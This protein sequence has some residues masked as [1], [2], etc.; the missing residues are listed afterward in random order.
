MLWLTMLVTVLHILVCLVLI[1]VVLLQQGGKA[2]LGVFAGAGSQTAFGGAGPATILHKLTIGAAVIFM[3]TC[4]FLS[5]NPGKSVGETDIT[6]GLPKTQAAKPVAPAP[7]TPA[8]GTSP[9]APQGAAPSTPSS[10][11][12]EGGSGA[13]KE[14][15]ATTGSTQPA[16]AP[17][18]QQPA[19]SATGDATKKP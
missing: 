11:T 16:G 6:K 8:P 19:G 14:T 5:L 1:L 9:G 18:A 4:L 17:A 7:G 12:T 15:G 3:I 2:D 13:P 10:S